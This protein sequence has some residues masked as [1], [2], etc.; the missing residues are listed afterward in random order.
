MTDI[1]I[2]DEFDNDSG[3]FV[4]YTA[5]DPDAAT[6]VRNLKHRN[7][8]S[9]NNGMTAAKAILSIPAPTDNYIPIPSFD[10][11]IGLTAVV[12]PN[13]GWTASPGVPTIASDSSHGYFKILS[14][15]IT[16]STPTTLTSSMPNYPVDL[17]TNFKDS[18]FISVALPDYDFTNLVAASCSLD[19]TSNASG[20]FA[21]GPTASVHFDANLNPLTSSTTELRFTRGQFNQNSIDLSK[22]T[23]VRF[24]INSLANTTFKVM[25][26]RL[27]GANW[28]QPSVDMDT[29]YG[30]LRKAA[31]LNSDLSNVAFPVPTLWRSNNFPGE[32]DP[33]P[34][35]LEIGASIFTGSRSSGGSISL[36]FREITKDEVTQLD[37]D[38]QTQDQLDA[39]GFQPD[40]GL[41]SYRFRTMSELQGLTMNELQGQTQYDLER[42]PDNLASSYIKATFSWI[43]DGTGTLNL[44]DQTGSGYF[45]TVSGLTTNTKYAFIARIVDTTA[46]LSI[47]GIDA[48]NNLRPDQIIF[49]SGIINDSSIIKRRQGRFGWSAN[50]NDGDAYIGSLL[51][52]FQSFA[53]YRSQPYIS[54]TPIVGAQLFVQQSGPKQLFVGYDISDWSGNS[55][56]ILGF[57]QAQSLSRQSYKVSTFGDLTYNGICS[58]PFSVI[59]ID[60]AAIEFDI[61]LPESMTS[62]RP[63][64]AF[65]RTNSDQ[66]IALNMPPLIRNQWQHI[67]IDL[68][69]ASSVRAGTYRFAL[70]QR[71]AEPAIW[72]VDNTSIAERVIFWQARAVAD[73]P[74]RAN[75]APWTGFNDVVNEPSGGVI[76]PVRGNELQLRGRALTQSARISGSPKFIPKYA[77]LGR[78][79]WSDEIPAAPSA[80]TAT[81]TATTAGTRTLKFVSTSTPDTTTWIVSNEWNFGDG[82]HQIGNEVTHV[83]ASSGTYTVQLISRDSYGLVSITSSAVSV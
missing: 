31:P 68:P 75:Y 14:L 56:T 74:W 8:R 30:L 76:F 48:A 52:R 81:F 17:L 78:T 10:T 3:E 43:G 55:Q 77:T 57:D 24:T 41:P 21:T 5:Y 58:N 72:W 27:I 69:L 26:M 9:I 20:N 62:D 37:L 82:Q 39:L 29:R 34:I 45:F 6:I 1:N 65:L 63:L 60:Q 19:L 64:L 49:N 46:N 73:D 42:V 36:Y 23:G 79:V 83:Y 54:N 53:E 47:I 32:R 28:T 66:L 59:N 15:S 12:S 16:A 50:L 51:S 61:Y 11:S 7:I 35:D 38:G 4:N 2:G 25:A 67:T 71:I 44:I 33:R 13:E 22:I 80:P 18:D 70:L 40:F